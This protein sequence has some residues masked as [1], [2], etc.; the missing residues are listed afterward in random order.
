[1]YIIYPE[2][3]ILIGGLGGGGVGLARRR[4]SE[5]VL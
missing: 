4:K 1:M 2:T 5:K 3:P